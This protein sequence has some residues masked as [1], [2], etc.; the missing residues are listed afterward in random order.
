[1]DK[2]SRDDHT[3]TKLFQDGRNDAGILGQD[4]RGQDR[5]IDA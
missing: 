2:G 5:A 4:S 3:R 1:M